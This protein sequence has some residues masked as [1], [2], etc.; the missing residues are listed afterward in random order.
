MTGEFFEHQEQLLSPG[1]KAVQLSQEIKTLFQK[2]QFSVTPE[3]PR[4]L[5]FGSVAD[6]YGVS[7]YT[8]ERPASNKL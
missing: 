2:P 8:S 7:A 1:K 3:L 4:A 6:L 5:D